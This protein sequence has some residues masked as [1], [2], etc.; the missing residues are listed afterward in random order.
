MT[1]LKSK[2]SIWDRIIIRGNHETPTWLFRLPPTAQWVPHF[3]FRNPTKL[4]SSQPPY[5]IGLPPLGKNLIVGKYWISYLGV[6]GQL[7]SLSLWVQGEPL[8]YFDHDLPAL[9]M[10]VHVWPH[11]KLSILQ[12][13]YSRRRNN[14]AGIAI[15]SNIM[16]PTIDLTLLQSISGMDSEWPCA[17]QLSMTR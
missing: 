13:K 4:A 15:T 3:S 12:N 9:P 14:Y 7:A 17:H 10:T 8:V 11:E 5:V 6:R 16:Q 2:M 1:G